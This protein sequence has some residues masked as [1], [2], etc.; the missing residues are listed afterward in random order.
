MT[1]VCCVELLGRYLDFV[2]VSN[3]IDLVTVY[4]V[5]LQVISVVWTWMWRLL[6]SPI[7]LIEQAATCIFLSTTAFTLHH[8]IFRYV[9]RE[10]SV[11]SL[12]IL[13][14]ADMYVCHIERHSQM[15]SLFSFVCLHPRGW[16][17]IRFSSKARSAVE[18][19]CYGTSYTGINGEKRVASLG[20]GD[21]LLYNLMLL[22]ALPASPSSSMITQL[23]ITGGSIISINIAFLITRRLLK[24]YRLRVAPGLPLPVMTFTT[25]IIL[26]K[27]IDVLC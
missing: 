21:L 16:Q 13:S 2:E 9:P 7:L 14:V 11:A 20:F 18:M 27:W 25:Y 12:W 10:V 22:L 15:L 23:W 6:P 8:C 19:G 3:Q 26:L 17:R 1:I 4:F 5:V 24:T